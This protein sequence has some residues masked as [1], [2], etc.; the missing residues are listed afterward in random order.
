M[1]G[2]WFNS[3]SLVGP[4]VIAV[5]DNSEDSARIIK[6]VHRA[7]SPDRGL[8][9]EV[10]FVAQKP[11]ALTYALIRQHAPGRLHWMTLTQSSAS[12]C[13]PPFQACTC[14]TCL[15]AFSARTPRVFRKRSWAASWMLHGRSC[16]GL[17]RRQHRTLAW[18]TR[19]PRREVW[20]PFGG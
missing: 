16:A 1:D 2:G 5:V 18:R 8:R 3:S 19:V 14:T 12:G 13:A 7:F 11:L 4:W 9:V 6:A 20:L 10:V 15:A 17:L